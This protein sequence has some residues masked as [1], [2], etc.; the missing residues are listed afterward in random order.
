[1]SDKNQTFI[2]P[3]ISIYAHSSAVATFIFD[4]DEGL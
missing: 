3:S 2:F 4:V 1:M